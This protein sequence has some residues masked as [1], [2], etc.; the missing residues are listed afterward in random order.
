M[1]AH[2]TTCLDH[3]MDILRW[4]CAA[5]SVTWVQALSVVPSLQREAGI[6]L[7]VKIES[8]FEIELELA[9]LLNSTL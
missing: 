9:L 2:S 8:K 4:S 6:S 5:C 7:Q 3:Y 1:P